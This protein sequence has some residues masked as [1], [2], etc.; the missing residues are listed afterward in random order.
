ME[1]RD[2]AREKKE[3]NGFERVWVSPMAHLNCLLLTN[4]L[5]FCLPCTLSSIFEELKIQ[6][7]HKRKTERAIPHQPTEAE[8]CYATPKA[9]NNARSFHCNKAL[10]IAS[11]RHFLKG[12]WPRSPFNARRSF[13]IGLTEKTQAGNMCWLI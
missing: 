8:K 2:R 12:E 3:D 7:R 13:K 10:F 11:E 6:P 4:A 1:G 5:T 9:K